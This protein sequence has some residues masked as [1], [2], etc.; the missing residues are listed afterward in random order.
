MAALSGARPGPA[1]PHVPYVP[2]G[3]VLGC[4]TLSWGSTTLRGCSLKNEDISKMDEHPCQKIFKAKRGH[5]GN[6]S[7]N[8]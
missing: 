1:D 2:A 4:R 8:I 5:C 3:Q 7:L 6:N